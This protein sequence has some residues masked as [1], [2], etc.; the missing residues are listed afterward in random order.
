MWMDI[1]F[2]LLFFSSFVCVQKQIEAG[3]NV[4]CPTSPPCAWE[5]EPGVKLF[6]ERSVELNDF[7]LTKGLFFKFVVTSKMF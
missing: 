7:C 1:L 5:Y 6:T 2:K 3:G 4:R